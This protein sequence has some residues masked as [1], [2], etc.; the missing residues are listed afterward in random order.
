MSAPPPPHLDPAQ[1]EPGTPE[2]VLRATGLV[3]QYKRVRAVDGISLSVGAGERVALLGPNGAG[4]TTTL[5][6]L[7]GVIT[8]DDGTIEISGLHL[9]RDRS[10]AMERVGFAAGYLPLPERVRVVEFLELF[11]RLYGLRDPG[12]AVQA[13]LER[14]EI[15]HLAKA[16]GNELS[17]GQRTL[18]GILKATLHQPRLLV[19]DE[20]T[21]SLDPDVARRVRTGLERLCAEEGTALLVT[22]HNMQEVERLCERIIFVSAGQVVADGT[23][24]EVA[25]RFGRVDLEGVFLHLAETPGVLPG[26][27]VAPESSS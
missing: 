4:K 11:G 19:L 7:L 3:K 1:Q 15:T 17:S 13:G 22:S 26:A 6:M 25:A 5:M 23:A 14:F 20:P 10:R 21:A 18:V 12:P 2:P 9:P 27:D 8:P 24:G 16:M